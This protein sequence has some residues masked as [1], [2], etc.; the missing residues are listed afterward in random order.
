MKADLLSIRVRHYPNGESHSQTLTAI[1]AVN[2]VY[3]GS[4]PRAGEWGSGARA[5]AL[6]AGVGIVGRLASGQGITARTVAVIGVQTVIAIAGAVILANPVTLTTAVVFAGLA[7][8]LG[9]AGYVAGS[10]LDGSNITV[11][12]AAA[13][14]AGGAL[15]LFAPA[16]L[17]VVGRATTLTAGQL[18]AFD[19]MWNAEIGLTTVAAEFAG[20]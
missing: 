7:G 19:V 17:G 8:A 1:A 2:Q 5:G 14:F 18:A 10:W 15:G 11:V 12:G 9:A 16:A 6:T 3:R 20:P 4:R 13:N